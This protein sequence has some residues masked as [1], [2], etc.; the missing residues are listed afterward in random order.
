MNR[1]NTNKIQEKLELIIASL[2]FSYLR[3]LMFWDSFSDK[4]RLGKQPG[5]TASRLVSLSMGISE[6][7][8]D[9][10]ITAE[11]NEDLKIEAKICNWPQF[12]WSNWTLRYNT[13]KTRKHYRKYLKFLNFGIWPH[14]TAILTSVGYCD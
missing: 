8:E 12:A 10:K 4:G 11:K 9:A 5:Q 7:I 13:V 14:F 1:T 2:V 3:K 6:E